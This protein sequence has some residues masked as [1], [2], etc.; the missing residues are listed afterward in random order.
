MLRLAGFFLVVLVVLQILRAVPV[1]GRIFDVPFLGFWGAAIL[2]SV[3]ASKLADAAL[4]RRQVSRWKRHLGAAETSHNQGKLG[5]LLV[6]R[7]RW[8]QAIAPL[9]RAVEGEPQVVEWRYRLGQALLRSGR[10][11]DAVVE[12]SKAT[13]LAEEHAYGGALM[14]LAEAA[15]RAGDPQASIAALDRRDRNH[16]DSPES[17]YRRGLALRALGRRDE[18]RASFRRAVEIARAST[19]YQEKQAR[20][21]ALRA[22]LLRFA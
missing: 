5:A 17:A 8:R 7:G 4:A 3:V 10:P 6:S 15:L 13:E 22:W 2:V 19:R 9:E 14:R 20:W 18:A 16:G 11:K 21:W 12:L 1:I